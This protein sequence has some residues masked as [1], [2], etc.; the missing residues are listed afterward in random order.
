MAEI[1]GTSANFEAEVINSDIPVVV[2]FWADWC[3]P[4]KM[5]APVLAEVASEKEG[6]VKVCKVNVDEE[7]ELAS[8]YNVM[9]IPMVAGF[10]NGELKNKIVG[11][12]SKAEY[13]N[14]VI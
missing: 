1:K 14:L 6:E 8:E 5:L 12:R 3:G 10:I 9:S 4:C 11:L 7:E 2:D 13:V